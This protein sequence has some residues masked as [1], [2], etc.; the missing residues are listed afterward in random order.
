MKASLGRKRARRCRRQS[1]RSR[2]PTVDEHVGEHDG[3]EGA[4][5]APAGDEHGGA[6]INLAD[7]GGLP[8]ACK[9]PQKRTADKRNSLSGLAAYL[10]P[11]RACAAARPPGRTPCGAVAPGGDRRLRSVEHDNA[12]RRTPRDVEYEQSVR[13]W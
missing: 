4:T 8:R 7:R 10:R 9:V 13:I 6:A 11:E 12:W 2:T 3:V 5:R 1:G